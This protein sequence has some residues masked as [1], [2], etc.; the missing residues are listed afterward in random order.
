MTTTPPV[1]PTKDEMLESLAAIA[2]AQW[3][4]F[5]GAAAQQGLTSTQAKLLVLL[6]RPLP[7]RELAALL[8]CD[9][10]NVTGIVDRLEAQGLARREADPRDRRV[11]RVIATDE[12]RDTVRR[13]RAD[14]HVMHRALDSLDPAEQD[15]LHRLVERMR[16]ALDA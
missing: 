16:P 1:A 3:R 7:M 12:G 4:D 11:K 8:G 2:G 13:V 14:M 10:S 5:A 6:T 9:A 15:A